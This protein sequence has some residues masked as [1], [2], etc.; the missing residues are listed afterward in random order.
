M[1]CRPLASLLSSRR[2][3]SCG[4]RAVV[5]VD[6]YAVAASGLLLTVAVD[7]RVMNPRSLIYFPRA[8]RREFCQR[9]R[10]CDELATWNGGVRRIPRRPRA[11]RRRRRSP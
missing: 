10:A 8:V 11:R 7:Q 3:G 5:F 1:R 6:Q 2:R 9:P 4:G